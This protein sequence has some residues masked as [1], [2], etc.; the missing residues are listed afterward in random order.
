MLTNQD[1]QNIYGLLCQEFEKN[2][3]IPL[4]K[5]ALY[6]KNQG[7]NYE[8]FGYKKMKSLLNDL[9]EFLEL[10]ADETVGH[11]KEEYVVVH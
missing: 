9:N 1:K 6:L 8:E 4:A 7:L 2:S 3:K 10:S 11:K 5:V